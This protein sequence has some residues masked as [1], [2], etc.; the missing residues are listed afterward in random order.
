MSVFDTSGKGVGY[1]FGAGEKAE[2]LSRRLAYIR[3]HGAEFLFSGDPPPAPGYP[4]G[5][6]WERYEEWQKQHG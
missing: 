1:N 6:K 4:R 3:K 5:E 2:L